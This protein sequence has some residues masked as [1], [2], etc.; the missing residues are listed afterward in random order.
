MSENEPKNENIVPPTASEGEQN[1]NKKAADYYAEKYKNTKI[2]AV[3]A[4]ILSF[5]PMAAV[6][7]PTNWEDINGSYVQANKEYSSEKLRYQKEIAEYDQR[8]KNVQQKIDA[9][10]PLV[11]GHESV[12]PRGFRP[13]YHY[14]SANAAEEEGDRLKGFGNNRESL[15]YYLGAKFDIESAKNYLI[16]KIVKIDNNLAAIQP[17]VAQEE[18]I[19]NETGQ[20]ESVTLT[21]PKN[22]TAE[23]KEVLKH[24]LDEVA[25]KMI[26]QNHQQ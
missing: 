12:P 22:L 24:Q 8:I 25:R 7:A 15:G 23:Q 21:I 3:L 2:G 6:S 9:V 11:E 1:L 16:S 10:T 18:A 20:T 19:V 17:K 5:A 26:E 13:N 14:D 4:S